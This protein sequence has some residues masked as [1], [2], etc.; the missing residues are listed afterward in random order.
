MDIRDV[1]RRWRRDR[2]QGHAVA[3]RDHQ[4]VAIQLEGLDSEREERQERQEATAYKGGAR[5]TMDSRRGRLSSCQR[6]R[7]SGRIPRKRKEVCLRKYLIKRLDDALAA[8]HRRKPVVYN[9]HRLRHIGGSTLPQP[10][11]MLTRRSESGRGSLLP[12]TKPYGGRLGGPEHP[13]AL[14]ARA[15]AIPARPL[16][17]SHPEE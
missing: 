10:R 3:A 7:Q 9:R 17:P 2:A 1:Q 5:Q 11:R 15:V 16:D 12:R 4:R 14:P 8:A 13:L 6:R